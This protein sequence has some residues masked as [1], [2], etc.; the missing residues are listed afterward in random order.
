MSRKGMNSITEVLDKATIASIVMI[1]VLV[2]LLT[3]SIPIAA[4]T[5]INLIAFGKLL[6]PVVTLSLIVLVLMLALG[7]LTIWQSVII[8]VIQQ[9]LMVKISLNLTRQFTHLSLTNFSVHHGPE[10]VNRFFEIVTINKAL[11]SLLLYGVNL[12]LQLFFGLV[13]LLFYHPLFLVFDGFIILSILLIVFIPY[14]KGLESAKEECAQKH[15][16]GAWLEELLTNRF[17]FRFNDYHQYAVHQA[18]KRL[19]SFLKARNT[20]FKQLIKHQ[21]GFYLLS[22]FAS[23][24]LLGMGGYLIINNQ[25]SLGQLVAAEI[26]LGAL[27]YTFKRFSVLLQ[28]YYDLVASE[29]KI[30]TVL[31][32]PCETIKTEL[33][34]LIIPMQSLTL[35]TQDQK[36][37]SSRMGDPLVIGVDESKPGQYIAELILGFKNSLPITI[38]VNNILCLEEQRR[39]LREHAL[40]IRD[41]E[42]FAGSIYDN[43][44]L[45]HPSFS[46]EQLKEL[47]I[48]FGLMDKIMRQPH[49]LK[50]IIFD[51]EGVFTPLE[52]VQLMAIRAMLAKPQL[53]IIDGALDKL[54]RKDI[55]PLLAQLAAMNET[56]LIII[57]CYPELIPLANR[58]VLS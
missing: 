53:L 46:T 36:E 9:K 43:L 41:N 24:L 44:R 18:D 10:L 34:E 22:A 52:L 16:V 42:W 1:S 48:A 8:E 39:S 4:Q 3:L 11:A 29:D 58:L 38:L 51:W 12:S 26:V 5:L 28:N 17:L 13:L 45:N 40:L 20:H 47:L 32:L 55:E 49:G 23:S 31:N 56:I 6:Q 15:Q 37:A 19:V 35:I 54:N 57:T 25:L 7:A 30:D 27:I 14:R 2:S 33:S 21:F 50:S